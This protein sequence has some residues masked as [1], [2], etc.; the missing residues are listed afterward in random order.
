MNSTPE[1]LR[2][3]RELQFRAWKD[4]PVTQDLFEHLKKLVQTRVQDWYEGAYDSS[5]SAEYIAK[6]SLA[7]GYCS[8]FNEILNLEADDLYAE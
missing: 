8:A 4:H 3:E 6:N 2:K 5:F 1:V 7:K